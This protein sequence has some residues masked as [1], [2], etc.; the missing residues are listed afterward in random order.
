MSA[1]NQMILAVAGVLFALVLLF[2]FFIRPRQAN[3]GQ[4]RGQIEQEQQRTQQLQTEVTRLRALQRE[5][6]QLQ[7]ALDKFRELVPENDE[8][9]DFIFQVQSAANQA[10]VGFVQITPE[11]PK[12][13][14]EGAPLAEVRA[15]VGAQGGYF[16]VQDFVRRLYDLDR[17]LRVD[18]VALTGV[19]DDQEAAEDGRVD[20][21]L[22]TRVF[23]ELPEGA[24][25]AAPAGTTTTAP[26]P[27]PAPAPATATP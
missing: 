4:V 6:P 24:A 5:A 26:V 25:A 16:A 2:L 1:R 22:T 21:L 3:L 17:A 18:T 11:L 27:A 14:P 23:F 19:E 12:Q 10:G 20:V 7:A 9:A 13:P 15:T 8:V